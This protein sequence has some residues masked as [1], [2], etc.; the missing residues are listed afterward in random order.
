M[1][2][3]VTLRTWKEVG[4][5]LGGLDIVPPGVVQLPEW[6]PDDR[7]SLGSRSRPVPMWCAVGRKR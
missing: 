6:Q 3:C 4:Q 2:E 7:A 5:F 1:S